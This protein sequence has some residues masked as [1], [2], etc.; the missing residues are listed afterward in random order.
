M[1]GKTARYILAALAGAALLLGCSRIEKEAMEPANLTA[2]IAEEVP[3]T[4]TSYDSFEGKF[5]WNEGDE[6]AVHIA[7]GTAN[8]RYETFKVLPNDPAE[9]AS[10]AISTT[11][12]MTRNAYAVYPASAAVASAYG[13]PTLKVSL[14]ATYDISDI[15][16]GTSAI[17]TSDFSPCP[18]VAINDPAV[19]PDELDFYHVGSLLRIT[20]KGVSPTT[21]KVRVTFDEY[22]T[23]TFAV[24]TP[25]AVPSAS[26]E[27]PKITTPD[28]DG[29]GKA[30]T[31][32]LAETSIGADLAAGNIVLNVPVPC[33]TFNSVTVE[34]LDAV[35]DTEATKTFDEKPLVFNRHHGKKLAFGELAFDFVLGPLLNVNVSYSGGAGTFQSSFVSY[36]T[37]DGG[38]TKTPV[39]YM[40]E[41]SEDEGVTWSVT[42]PSWLSGAPTGGAHAGSTMGELLRVNVSAQV[43]SAPD[44]HHEELSKTSRAKTDFD[45]ST[46]NVS[47]GARVSRTTANCYVVQ[48]PGTYRLPLVYGNGVVQGSVNELAFRAKASVNATA[49]RPDDGEENFLGRFKDH[50]DNNIMSPYIAIQQASKAMSA[51]LVWQDVQGL[52]TVDPVISGAGENAYITFSVPAETITQGNA[53]IAVLVDDDSDGISETIAW[54]WH[55]WVTEEDLTGVKEGGFNGYLFAPVNVGWCDG[56]TEM[57]EARSFQI[58]VTQEGS[59]LTRTATLT[60]LERTRTTRGTSPYYQWGRK[61]PLQAFKGYSVIKPYYPSSAAYAPQLGVD[62]SFSIG[63]AIQN[64]FIQNY[65][66]SSSSNVWCSSIYYNAWN[67]VIDMDRVHSLIPERGAPVS[68]TI[69]D[70]SPVGFKLFPNLAEDSGRVVSADFSYGADGATYNSSGLFFPYTGH[71]QPDGNYVSSYGSAGFFWSA[72][73]VIGGGPYMVVSTGYAFLPSSSSALASACGSSVRPI[74]DELLGPL[75]VSNTGMSGNQLD[76]GGGT[77][78]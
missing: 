12:T 3:A 14:P 51:V 34:T 28:A 60:Q 31:F 11:S 62:G 47:T 24:A 53:L 75:G 19:A 66:S 4:R 38:D 72:A 37:S 8:G 21:R 2:R 41:Y 44:L 25:S 33:V 5:L 7:D 70:P 54:S 13:S 65:S 40:L 6:I 69:Y 18:M 9:T 27:G 67:S 15:V 52:V 50:L 32:T 48:G 76:M 16:A 1:K 42:A 35:G 58:R 61:D 26:V 45:L 29:R 43:N 55:I 10:V 74:V 63:A 64:P 30:V 36:K 56:G 17:K 59:G 46:I 49:F 71:L 78:Q 23:G 20:L 77:W 57:Y 68:K 22:A 39:P 73:P